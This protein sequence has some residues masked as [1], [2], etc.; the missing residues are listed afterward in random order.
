VEKSQS[1]F[2]QQVGLMIWD[3]ERHIA[4]EFALRAAVLGI[5]S[6][7]T[8]FLRVLEHQDGITQRELADRTMM[9]GS[10]TAKALS[11]LEQHRLIVREG[12][13]D[14]GRKNIIW[15]TKEG[16]DLCRRLQVE[17]ELFNRRLLVGLTDREVKALKRSLAK[18]RENLT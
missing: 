7:L 6:G 18:I 14:D 5:A 16:R 13:L 10:T 17:A 4:R 15:L 9:R 2:D 12:S 11:E 3:V 1:I 8:A